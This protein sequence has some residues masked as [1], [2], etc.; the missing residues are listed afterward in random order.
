M[1]GRPAGTQPETVY[2]E[3]LVNIYEGVFLV[4]LNKRI[5]YWNK[6]AEKLTG[7]S[8]S[9]MLGKSCSKVLPRHVDGSDTDLFDGKSPIEKPLRDGEQRDFEAF[10][11]RR[12]GT[13][14]PVLMR[15]APVKSSAG[16]IIGAIELFA[17]NSSRAAILGRIEELE[18]HALIDPLTGLGNRRYV[19]MTLRG[20]IDEMQRYLTPFGIIFFDIDDFKSVNDTYGHNVGDVVLKMVADALSGQ[21]RPFDVFGRWGGEEFIGIFR[22]IDREGLLKLG[23]RLRISVKKA[24]TS[25]EGHQ[26]NVTIS[27]GGTIARVGET[28]QALIRRADMLMYESKGGGKNRVTIG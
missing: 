24:K 23:E 26:V 20:R 10:I 14:L 25:E 12:D 7:F 11:Y 9:D 2:R 17:D 21:A 8:A 3:I 4:D 15:V 27:A 13:R 19:E 28:P 16:E 1:P 22:S 18:K 6:V 5:T